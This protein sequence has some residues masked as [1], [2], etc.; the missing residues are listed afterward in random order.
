MSPSLLALSCRIAPASYGPRIVEFRQVASLSVEE[1]TYF[2]VS[3]KKGAPWS[4][5]W[6]RLDQT[7]SNI[8]YVVRPSRIARERSVSALMASP[9]LGSKPKSNVHVGASTMPSS[10]VN[11]WTKIAPSEAI[12]LLLPGVGVVVIA[13]ALPETGP[14]GRRELDPVQPLRA[15]PE[16]ARWDEETHR[17]AV[18]RGQRLAVGFVRDE[19]VLFVERREGHVLGVAGRGVGDREMRRLLR[20]AECRKLP[21]VDP[22]E[23]GVEAA[24]PRDAMDVRRDFGR[25]QRPQLLVVECDLLLDLAEDP[26]LPGGDVDVRNVPRVENGPLLGQVLARRQ[27][28]RV[29]AGG[30]HL[31]LGFRA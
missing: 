4:S 19:R 18:L 7:G 8:S 28:R 9:I 11:S 26:Q 5:S 24:P 6:V 12:P 3:L 22:A 15:F 16:V 10:V 17:T 30:A 14:V 1:T 25:R 20:L 2:G 13:V 27:T 29:V 21:P 31:L 23:S